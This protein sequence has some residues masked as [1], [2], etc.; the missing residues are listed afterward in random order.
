MTTTCKA[1]SPVCISLSTRPAYPGLHIGLGAAESNISLTPYLKT[2]AKRTK[3]IAGKNPSTGTPESEKPKPSP[4]TPKPASSPPAKTAGGSTARAQPDGAKLPPS[5]RLLAL[6]RAMKA[7]VLARNLS[8]NCGPEVNG[9]ELLFFPMKSQDG[10]PFW[11]MSARLYAKERDLLQFS[12]TYSGD[13]AEACR[14]VARFVQECERSAQPTHD[15][16]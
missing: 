5:P 3:A 2:M 4:A 9:E 11:Q 16:L 10:H 13:D 15:C 1:A 12:E 7:A 14:A 8:G 6:Q